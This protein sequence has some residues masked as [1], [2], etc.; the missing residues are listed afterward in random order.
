MP[1]QTSDLLHIAFYVEPEE[2]DVALLFR[3]GKLI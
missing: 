3:R 1:Q 2:T